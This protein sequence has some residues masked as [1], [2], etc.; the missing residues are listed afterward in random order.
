ML[1][2]LDLKTHAQNSHRCYKHCPGTHNWNATNCTDLLTESPS[3][4]PLHA[5]L[6]TVCSELKSIL[7]PTLGPG[8]GPWIVSALEQHSLLVS[9][10]SQAPFSLKKERK[11]PVIRPIFEYHNS[12]YLCVTSIRML[13]GTVMTLSPFCLSSAAPPAHK[14]KS[15]P[16]RGCFDNPREACGWNQ[17]LRE[18][19]KRVLPLCKWN[20]EGVRSALQHFSCAWLSKSS[21]IFLNWNPKQATKWEQVA[22]RSIYCQLPSLP[23]ESQGQLILSSPQIIPSPG[24]YHCPNSHG[25][26]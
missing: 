17:A 9:K 4:L 16:G 12:H 13:R 11:F 8:S 19:C 6:C 24:H 20:P 22:V 1:Q 3:K 15:P 14:G 10:C 25:Q 21:V 5:T 7:S 23:R 26:M 2:H 18:R